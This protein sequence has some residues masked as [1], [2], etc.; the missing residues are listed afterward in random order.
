M[1]FLFSCLQIKWQV[2]KQASFGRKSPGC[3]VMHSNDLFPAGHCG[4]VRESSQSLG[5]W[6]LSAILEAESPG[7]EK[8]L[9][10]EGYTWPWLDVP[11]PLSL[12]QLTP[13]GLCVP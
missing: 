7:W 3:A 13:G 11:D 10:G 4:P 8:G 12:S 5:L 9:G 1:H 2:T 6:A